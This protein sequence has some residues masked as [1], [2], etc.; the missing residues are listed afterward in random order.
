[1][2]Q[3]SIVWI[4]W[5]EYWRSYLFKAPANRDFI[6][7]TLLVGF[8]T[9]LVMAAVSLQEGLLEKHADSLLGK[10]APFGFPVAIRSDIARARGI[11]RDIIGAF[12][13]EAAAAGE[14]V[15]LSPPLTGLRLFPYE[16]MEE[17]GRF[18][19]VSDP[20]LAARGD[21][22]HFTQAVL[23]AASGQGFRFQGWAVYRDDPLW[24]WA[25]QS[26]GKEISGEKFPQRI[27]LSRHAWQNFDYRAYRKAVLENVPTEIA[28]PT[29]P[30]RAADL[31]VLWMFFNYGR[32]VVP[33][34]VLWVDNIPS[35]LQLAFLFPLET[36]Q[37][38][39]AAWHLPSLVFEPDRIDV[40]KA[41]RIESIRLFAN[42]PADAPLIPALI[43][44]IAGCLGKAAGV[45]DGSALQFARSL[46]ARWVDLCVDRTTLNQ[47]VQISRT[48][49]AVPDPVDLE[50]PQQAT[51]GGWI[52]V[53]CARL[54][55]EDLQHGR[56]KVCPRNPLT[57]RRDIPV[58]GWFDAAFSGFRSAVVYVPDRRKVHDVAFA[59]T[60][61]KDSSGPLFWL[62]PTY[63][64]AL[65]KVQ[66]L[67]RVVDYLS[68][69]ILVA[70]I[71]FALYLMTNTMALV[72]DHRKANY[73]TLVAYGLTPGDIR[74]MLMVQ[75]ALTCMVGGFS[76]GLAQ[77]AVKAG[78][79]LVFAAS[80]V[81]ALGRNTLGITD[82]VILPL[83]SW[84]EFLAV[85][86][87]IY[88]VSAVI[89][90]WLVHLR[91][92]KYAGPTDL[93]K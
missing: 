55:I 38:A 56:N 81:A 36:L 24:Q 5:K 7:L 82:T 15:S 4:A 50:T 34:E 20:V 32:S 58:N 13:G 63:E 3:R 17:G 80:D 70:A 2:E 84:Q 16:L 87:M 14:A 43:D 39:T 44:A 45:S 22:E 27:V 12:A 49:T 92:S 60:K 19:L 37:A 79:N 46:P 28:R 6:W 11:D 9:A 54:R 83:L 93:L 73:G 67:S 21:R 66:Y 23:N 91:M 10:V 86:T 88:L 35:P 65:N 90:M 85:C 26:Q 64:S 53:P 72:I 18:A 47:P 89:L 42:H 59:L 71:L 33:V 40:G 69:P 1:M 78:S 41:A 52:G 57:A 76:F 8:I 31:K 61:L 30:E 77:E 51:S 68:R 62:D 29:L 48:E 75:L 74:F 25:H